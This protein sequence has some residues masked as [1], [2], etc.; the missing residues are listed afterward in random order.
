VREGGLEAQEV[1]GL[2]GR[3]EAIVG[4]DD[5]VVEEGGEGDELEVE[6]WGWSSGKE[7]FDVGGVVG[8]G[9]F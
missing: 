8:E 4:V 5:T 6:D 7:D 3:G 2:G 9:G 1:S